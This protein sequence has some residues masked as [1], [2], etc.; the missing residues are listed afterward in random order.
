M[1]DNI[2]FDSQATTEFVGRSGVLDLVREFDLTIRQAI[3]VSDHLPV[4][5]EF[6]SYEGGQVGRIAEANSGAAR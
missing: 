1:A 6:S 3:E 5:A 2:L 4:W